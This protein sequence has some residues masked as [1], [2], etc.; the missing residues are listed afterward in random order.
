MEK[1]GVEN[2]FPQYV[3]VKNLLKKSLK[4]CWQNG[5]VVVLYPSARESGSKISKKHKK[6]LTKRIGCANI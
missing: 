2:D 1:L 3:V 5:S 6:V 4:K